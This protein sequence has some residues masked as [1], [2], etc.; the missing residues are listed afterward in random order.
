[1]GGP[2]P[3]TNQKYWRGFVLGAGIWCLLLLAVILV[4]PYR[5][6]WAA[7]FDSNT[8]SALGLG[9]VPLDQVVRNIIRWALGFLGLIAVIMVIYGGFLWMTAAG[10][11]QRIEKAKKIIMGAI[12]GLVIILLSFAIVQFVFFG[13]T[14]STGNGND[15]TNGGPPPDGGDSAQFYV[16][17]VSPH[18]DEDNV[19]LCRFVQGVFNRQINQSTGA[20]TLTQV[21]NGQAVAGAITYQDGNKIKLDPSADLAPQKQ[22]RALIPDTVEDSS[23]NQLDQQK[24]WYFTTGS[25][26]DN[27]PPR[28]FD[29][30]PDTGATDICLSTPIVVEFNEPMDLSTLIVANVTV[31]GPGNPQVRSVD[32]PND[33]TMAI[34][35]NSPLEPNQ[36]YTVTLNG[37][38]GHIADACGNPLD[39]NGDG[40]GGDNYDWSFTT[41]IGADCAPKIN[42]ISGSGYYETDVTIEGTNF[43]S[44]PTT[45]VFNN[46]AT[47]FN[48]CFNA[49]YIPNAVCVK[50]WT[51]TRIKVTLPASGGAS[52]GAIDGLVKV[53]VGALESNGKDFDVKAPHV[54]QVNPASGGPGQ[55]VTIT[56]TNFGSSAGRVL[57]R[58]TGDPDIEGDRPSCSSWWQNDQIIVKVPEGFSLNDVTQIQ[59]DTSGNRRSN[60][61]DFQITNQVG[62]GLCSITPA[63][64]GADTDVTLIGE[65]LGGAGQ[66]KFD[67]TTADTTVWTEGQ[68]K[69]KVPDI[70]DSVNPYSVTATVG[71]LV[72]NGLPFHKPCGTGDD[73][74]HRACAGATCITASGEAPDECA[75]DSQ[76]TGTNTHSECAGAMCNVVDGAGAN[77]CDTPD[78]CDGEHR[79]CA[80]TSCI[81]VSGEAADECTDDSQCTDANTHSECAGAMCNVVDG[82]G[83]NQC[84]TP[85]DCDGEHRACAGTTCITA[86]GEAPDECSNDS[87]CTDANTH[88]EC[89][90][91]M[92]NVVDG[93]GANQCAVPDDCAGSGTDCDSDP[94]TPACQP[95]ACPVGETCRDTDC[96]CWVLPS[97]ACS[98]TQWSCTPNP[99]GCAATQGCLNDCSCADRPTLTSSIPANLSV[100]ICRNVQFSWT[101]SE[102]MSGSS[103]DNDAIQLTIDGGAAA[104]AACSVDKDC[105]SDNCSSNL[106]VGSVV[107]GSYSQPSDKHNIYG[108][109]GLLEADT[110]YRTK[111]L[112]L[113][114][115]VLSTDGLGMTSDV[116]YTF[117]TSTA[118]CDVNQVRVDPS[119]WQFVQRD[120][121]RMFT[122][123]AYHG[124]Q[125][126][127]SIPGVYE[128]NWTWSTDDATIIVVGPINV[129]ATVGTIQNKNGST[130]I[131]AKASV[132]TPGKEKEVTGRAEIRVNMCE[133]PW[134]DPG[135]GLFVPFTDADTHFSFWYCT[136]DG[137]PMIT[138]VTNGSSGA[139]LIKE[140]FFNG[141]HVCEGAAKACTVDA[142][143]D[144]VACTVLPDAVGVR[145]MT[146]PNSQSPKLWYEKRLPNEPIPSGAERT[147]DGFQSIRVGRTS[148]VDA[149]NSY[150]DGAWH[151]YTNIYLLSFSENSKSVT[152]EVANALIGNWKFVTNAGVDFGDFAKPWLIR[153]TKR[154]ADLA[155]I[156][157]YLDD[158]RATSSTYPNLQAGSY[159]TRRSTSAWPSWQASL[160]N[161]LGKGLP[162]D[163][164]NLFLYGSGPGTCEVPPYDHDTCWW[165]NK[166][167]YPT[168]G[169]R[170]TC[171][172]NS[173]VY[174]YNFVPDPADPALDK[175]YL[176]TMLEYPQWGALAPAN[177]CAGLADGSSCACF[178]YT[179]EVTP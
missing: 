144:G 23:G 176:Y 3:K 103:A 28:V 69:G 124:D 22:Y 80:G 84:D 134:P 101:F 5:F 34:T 170:F 58:K 45:T 65:A 57:F 142:D 93:A 122:A 158:Y 106:C 175:S 59:I 119:S 40:T 10:N 62:P 31:A 102:T 163:P 146:N 168:D 167:L 108:N 89:A 105:A 42:S 147:I 46:D 6:A 60:L 178:N 2:I 83:A 136:D 152:Q 21:D 70:A 132:T 61:E 7:T 63:C 19:S 82:A 90:G 88:S 100:D 157:H 52:N 117:K 120:A 166:T 43:T 161:A 143:C 169:G 14:N 129:A 150:F 123:S 154:L 125:M 171:Q 109:F 156:E 138:N 126:I 32:I 44:I 179:R 174:M 74:E 71:G 92:C 133:H 8:G 54:S 114:N 86:S 1:M 33:R 26:S 148:Y 79:A 94:A 97:Y 113:A 68:I 139:D 30:W 4:W 127:L 76:C 128:Y 115:G 39:G 55:F 165:G 27:E 149:A 87:Q 38:P 140:Y 104:G 121:S 137:L 50:E 96:R 18:E 107:R 111:L 118:I 77:Q 29:T 41:G 172:A 160:G 73:G 116:E 9:T 81:T 95:G 12:I 48:N 47:A 155:D 72:S 130:R 85:D 99:A 173:H 78:D 20:L 56:G 64:G 145:V 135:A 91:A 53:R 67:G 36:D 153:D 24:E 177:P 37:A 159:L 66:L 17:L 13:V 35:L 141:L 98:T 110:D 51:N 15:N 131:N 49:S 11:E 162:T 164:L 16:R 75:N 112:G 25:E 151:T